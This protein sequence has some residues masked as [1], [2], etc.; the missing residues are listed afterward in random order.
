VA[1]QVRKIAAILRQQVA[2]ISN[3]KA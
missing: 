2:T 1:R 3:T